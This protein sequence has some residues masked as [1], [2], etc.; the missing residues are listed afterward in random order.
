MSFRKKT[1]QELGRSASE[2]LKIPLVLVLDN[3]RSA[4]NVGSLFRSADAFGVDH[5]HLCGITAQPPHREILKTALGATSSVA[6]TY[7]ASS[8]DALQRLSDQ[9]YTLCAL[10]QSHDSRS[11]QDWQWT[12]VQAHVALILGNEVKGVEQSLLDQCDD[13]LEITQVGQK[14]SLNV[15]VSGG[16]AMHHIYQTFAARES[17]K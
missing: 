5:I 7:H 14:H 1:M 3:V 15:A 11:L 9:G 8:R 17:Q 2:S 4:Q 6:W 16:I 12:D 10:E 13:V